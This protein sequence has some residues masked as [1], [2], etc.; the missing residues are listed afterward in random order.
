MQIDRTKDFR[1]MID[2]EKGTVD[3]AIFSDQEIYDLEMERI[4]ARAWN[5]M[6]HE[7]QIPKPGDFFLS[8]IGE[9]SVIATRDRKGG[10]QVFLNTCRH[11]GNAVCRAESGNAKAFF[12]T[13]HGWTYDLEGKLIGV[14]GYKEFYHERLDRAKWGLVSAAKVESYKGFVFATMD[15]DAPSLEDFL[16]AVGRLG[17][18]MVAARGE[19]VMFEGIQ[20][21]VIGCN[22]KMAVDNLF[23]WYHVQITHAS[24]FQT[25]LAGTP[26]QDPNLPA[27][28][29]ESPMKHRVVLGD[30]G[31]AIG[32]PRLSAEE[33]NKLPPFHDKMPNMM[34][35]RDYGWRGS[36]EAV[37]VL[38]QLGGTTIGHPNIFPNLWIASGG[39][40]L[41]LRLPKGLDKCEMWWFTLREKGLPPQVEF[42]RRAFSQTSFGPAGFLEQEDGENWDQATRATRGPIARRYPLNYQMD[43]EQRKMSSTNGL[44]YIDT[45]VSEHAQL[46]LWQSWADWMSA[47]NWED[48]KQHHSRAE[49]E[50]GE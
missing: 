2:A 27:I 1:H 50:V 30:Y 41:C 3:R 9:E 40:Q 42:M 28:D 17:L 32:G 37:E 6:C 13:Y 18:D 35:Y 26:P 29:T 36:P 5:F 10:L 14:P 47:D 25:L 19:M 23:D 43:S 33:W 45:N 46:W 16:G 34:P 49:A 39:T 8:Y 7:S 38:G 12:C 20:K 22:W 11:R 15:P 31:H 24:A 44:S 48:L 4:F 21:N